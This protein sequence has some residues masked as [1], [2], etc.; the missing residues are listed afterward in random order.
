M[1]SPI[2][3]IMISVGMISFHAPTVQE[4]GEAQLYIISFAAEGLERR[5][6]LVRQRILSLPNPA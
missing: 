2:W 3:G 4:E 6:P 1:D 5:E